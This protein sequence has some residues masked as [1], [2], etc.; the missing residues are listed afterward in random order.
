MIDL[1]GAEFMPL[2]FSVKTVRISYTNQIFEGEMLCIRSR[3][4]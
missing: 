4:I 2:C 3:F 1:H